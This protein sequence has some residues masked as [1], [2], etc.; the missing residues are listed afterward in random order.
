M[1]SKI[2]RSE[3][4]RIMDE[5]N[6]EYNHIVTQIERMAREGEDGATVNT[7]KELKVRTRLEKDG[8]SL[9]DTNEGT[10]WIYWG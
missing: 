3:A 2:T 1:I 10:T 4:N 9:H 7:I 6:K 8:F 5:S